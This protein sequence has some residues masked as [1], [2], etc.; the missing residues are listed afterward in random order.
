MNSSAS[1]RWLAALGGLTLVSVAIPAA[2]VLNGWALSI[3][4][5]WFIVATFHAQALTVTQAIGVTVVVGYVTH[6][7]EVSDKTADWK[8]SVSAIIAKPLGSLAFGWIITQFM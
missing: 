7:R 4:W 8:S 2:V 6:Q 3:L 1:D 5:R